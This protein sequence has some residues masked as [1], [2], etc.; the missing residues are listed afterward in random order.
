MVICQVKALQTSRHRNRFGRRIIPISLVLS[1]FLLFSST[2]LLTSLQSVCSGDIIPSPPSANVS[3]LGPSPRSR[4]GGS[5]QADNLSDPNHSQTLAVGDFNGD[6]IQDLAFS[7][8]DAELIVGA[9]LRTSGVVYVLFGRKEFPSVIDT[10]ASQPGGTDLTILGAADGDRF[11]FA[12][13]AADVNGDGVDDLIVGAPQVSSA[14]LQAM[15]A[16]YVLLGSRSIGGNPIIDLRQQAADLVIHGAG[17]RFGAAIAVGDAGGPMVTIPIK[18]LFVGAPGSSLD[19]NGS[20]YLLFGRPELGTSIH[21]IDIAK[22]ADFTITGL[23]RQWLGSALAIGDFNGDGIGDLFAGAPGADRPF[24][25]DSGSPLITPASAAGAVFGLLGPFAFG[26]HIST[27]TAGQL[28][29]FYGADANHHFGQS[30]AAADVTGD[31]VADLVVA[32]PEAAGEWKDASTGI[33]YVMSGHAGAVYAFAGSRDISPRRFDL[34]A[35]NPFTAYVSFGGTWTGFGLALGS[36]NVEGNADAVADVIIGSPG[37]VSDPASRGVGRGGVLVLFG[38]RTLGSVTT[39]PRSPFNP[40]PEPEEV[41]VSSFPLP[42][43]NGFGFAVATGDLNGDGAG[44]LIVAAPFAEAA[45]RA[46]AGQVLIWFGTTRPP[47][48][49]GT[50]PRQRCG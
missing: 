19:S 3:I 31:G 43:N 46:Q 22:A 33:T 18:D 4:L 10:A 50:P 28:L 13:A 27:D 24:R 47:A 14:S 11:G 17:D 44:D 20:A 16:A 49:G 26:G 29:S 23:A 36:Y 38:G 45:G 30:V 8:P 2:N 40:P 15:G 32:A 12:V 9:A 5:G 41:G 25:D 37:G 7:A 48:G 6:G 42:Q 1:V 39:R 21:E 35:E 34:A